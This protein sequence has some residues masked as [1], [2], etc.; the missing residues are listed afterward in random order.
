MATI[1][2]RQGLGVSLVGLNNADAARWFRQRDQSAKP[3]AE[4]TSK[5]HK[6]VLPAK[7]IEI[8]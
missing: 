5:L 4:Q 1:M 8:L 3:A 7:I 6:A 2:N